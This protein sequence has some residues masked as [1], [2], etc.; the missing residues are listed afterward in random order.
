MGERTNQFR[1][2]LLVKPSI[3]NRSIVNIVVIVMSRHQIQ[4]GGRIVP[5]TA[6]A[7]MQEP[8]PFAWR[9]AG[10]KAIMPS[11]VAKLDVKC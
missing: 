9:E 6:G 1:S 3:L 11:R 5:R 10:A 8:V 7:P 2:E 4:C